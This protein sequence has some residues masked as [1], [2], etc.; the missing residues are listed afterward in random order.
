MQ[1]YLFSPIILYPLWKKPL[2]GLIN[3]I[4]FY[5]ISL[6][7]P[8]Y[9]AWH[10]EYTTTELVTP[11]LIAND[12]FPYFYI[13]S[14]TR[15]PPYFLGMFLGLILYKTKGKKFKIHRALV[16]FNWLASFALLISMIFINNVFQQENY[17][18]NKLE[19]SFYLAFSRSFWALAVAWI[20]FAC[21]NGY[22]GFINSFLSLH[23]FKIVG[24]ISYSVFLVHMSFQYLKNG[25]TKLPAYFS[26]LDLVS[27]IENCFFKF[28]KKKN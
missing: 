3:L 14:H 24:R 25:A 18:Y 11:R 23:F 10:N 21:A 19:A 27:C 20:V 8:F 7:I 5:L 13:T 15:A 12:F 17:E 9:T 26:N 28:K 22:G 4:I 1:F 16:I 6:S 2:F